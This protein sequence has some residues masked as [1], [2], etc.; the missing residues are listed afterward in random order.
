MAKEQLNP[1]ILPDS[2]GNFGKHGGKIGH[3][4]LAKALEE[5]NTA[6]HNIIGDEDFINEMKRL[7]ATYVGRPSPIYHAKSLSQRGAQIFLKREDLN[8]TGAHKI[9][10]W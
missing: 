3:P 10:H 8:H 6:F 4:E 5:L 7:Q 9:N 2:D 1:M